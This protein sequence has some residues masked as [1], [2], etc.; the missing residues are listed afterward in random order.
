MR[1]LLILCLFLQG[2]VTTKFHKHEWDKDSGICWICKA[3][4]NPIPITKKERIKTIKF[5]AKDI[6]I[7][8]IV[9]ETKFSKSYAIVLW[10][11]YKN[12]GI[13]GFADYLIKTNP[14]Q[15]TDACYIQFVEQVK[16]RTKIISKDNRQIFFQKNKNL[17]PEAYIIKRKDEY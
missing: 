5:N 8:A 11:K 3:E 17:Q 13:K 9:F 16:A 6:I 1:Y 4:W 10:E 7:E 2:C 14:L 15:L 12:S